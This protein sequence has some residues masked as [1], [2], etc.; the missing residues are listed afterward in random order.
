MYVNRKT[1]R[2]V[3]N[4]LVKFNTTRKEVVVTNSQRIDSSELFFAYFSL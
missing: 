3:E 2:S 4:V 1:T